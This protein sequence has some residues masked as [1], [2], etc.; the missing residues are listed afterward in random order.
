MSASFYA[1]WI[2]E[3]GALVE[4]AEIKQIED[5]NFRHLMMDVV[6]FGLA[7]T[8]T[9][10][11]L[12]VFAIRLGA[13]PAEQGLLIGLQGLVM[14]FSTLFAVRWRNRFQTTSE[15]II[16]PGFFF[17]FWFLLPV[18]TPFFPQPFQVPWLLFS[19]AFTGI[20]QGI[21]GSL[22]LTHMREAVGDQR[23]SVLSS[24]RFAA[25]NI[26]LC[27]TAVAFGWILTVIPFPLNYQVM[28]G[29][30]FIF[31]LVSQWH[32]TQSKTLYPVPVLAPVDSSSQERVWKLPG[33]RIV[34]V[35]GIVTHLAFLSVN[36]IIPMV[37]VKTMQADEAY[38]GI[39]GLI[40]LVGGILAGLSGEWFLRRMSPRRLT[41]LAVGMTAVTPLVIAFAPSLSFALG[42]AMLNGMGWTLVA[43][44]LYSVLVERTPNHLMPRA[45]TLYQQML[46]VGTFVGPLIGSTLAGAGV[47]LLAVLLIGA[48][49]RLVGGLVLG[50][51]RRDFGGLFLRAPRATV[52]PTV[53]AG[54]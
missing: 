19:V 48:G 16:I 22:F 21:A 36:A 12:S 44:G 13:T 8:A 53:A 40:E 18:F 43:I 11:F 45:T 29:A 42:G 47:N 24:R 51:H 17:R 30:A 27:I 37:L 9:A 50:I 39:F 5:K 15:A 49:L 38:M 31:S 23:V 25:M 33:W 41:G 32:V 26:G 52:I 14:G 7:L 3:R 20:G 10:R 4:R 6:W 1:Y 54:D 28:F 2:G 34:I 46:A 35:A